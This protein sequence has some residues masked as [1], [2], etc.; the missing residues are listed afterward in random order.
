MFDWVLNTPLNRYVCKE[1]NNTMEQLLNNLHVNNKDSRQ[2]VL[3]LSLLWTVNT[4]K[5]LLLTCT[6]ETSSRLKCPDVSAFS[7]DSKFRLYSRN[8]YKSIDKKVNMF[9]EM[10]K[11]QKPAQVRQHMNEILELYL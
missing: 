7:S 9:Y 6:K 10:Y 2:L 8:K 5:T 3:L 11:S 4:L 1:I